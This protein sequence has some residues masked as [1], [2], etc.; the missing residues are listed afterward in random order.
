MEHTKALNALEAPADLIT[1]ATSAPNTFVF[2]ELL[3]TP[4]IQALA[5]ASDE[6]RPYLT[7]L[8]I[9]AWGTWMDYQSTPD[10]PP[11]TPAQSHKLRQL[12]LLPLSRSPKTLTYP[13][14]LSALSLPN[15]RI[16]EDLIISAIYAGLLTAKL[17]TQS[18][19]LEV[20]SVAPLRD[21]PPHGIS[22]MQATLLEWEGRCEGV[23]RD[24]EFQIREVR[25]RNAERKARNREYMRLQA[26]QLPPKD[27]SLLSHS[28]FVSGSITIDPSMLGKGKGTGKRL[29]VEEEGNRVRDDGGGRGG[30]QMYYDD[31][32]EIDELEGPGR[33]GQR[34]TPRRG[35][36]KFNAGGGK[37]A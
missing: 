19:H 27:S 8:Q 30:E 22:A 2:A 28:S 1:R 23:L 17:N 34:K 37:K 18:Q 25:R 32:M 11:L 16:L 35:E 5:N 15:T 6:W 36:G 33:T 9:F 14:L 10:L 12:T 31:E 13:H 29:A 21:V 4:N 3:E 20:S 26:D 24:I 7:L